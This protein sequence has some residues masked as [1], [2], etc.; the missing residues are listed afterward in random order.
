MATTPNVAT[1]QTVKQ[2]VRAATQGGANSYTAQPLSLI[3]AANLTN[4]LWTLL[5]PSGTSTFTIQSS[6]GTTATITGSFTSGTTVSG[7]VTALSTTALSGVA[8]T[9]NA[10]GGQFLG[11]GAVDLILGSGVSLSVNSL[12]GAT[13]TITNVSVSTANETIAYPNYVGTPNAT[14]TWVDDATVHAYQLVGNGVVATN[15]GIVE[16]KQV[17]QIQTNFSETQVYNGYFTLYSGNL[18]QTKQRNTKQQQ[19]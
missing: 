19:C 18:N 13:P 3:N 10:N 4:G 6:L 14:P 7:L 12:T 5:V 8:F 17:R 15:S 11:T 1:E 16:Q 2:T 9:V